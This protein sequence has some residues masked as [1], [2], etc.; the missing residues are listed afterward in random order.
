M[1]VDSRAS[2]LD[3]VA[4]RAEAR[5]ARLLRLDVPPLAE[6]AE[7]MARLICGTRTLVDETADA[8]RE[9]VRVLRRLATQLLAEP[10]DDSDS[11]FTVWQYVLNL[12]RVTEAL[13]DVSG[14]VR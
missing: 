7:R 14:Q 6:T 13:I 3:P 8:D 5:Q 9:A 4:L 11:A 10:P 12:A 1:G 2:E